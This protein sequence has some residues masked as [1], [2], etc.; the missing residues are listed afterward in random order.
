MWLST[1]SRGGL[2]TIDEQW[3]LSRPLMLLPCSLASLLCDNRGDGGMEYK[4]TLSRKR[5]RAL[6]QEVPRRTCVCDSGL[7]YAAVV[8]R[9]FAT[10]ANLARV[11]SADCFLGLALGGPE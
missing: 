10:S 11:G 3:N 6:A 9:A 2:P 8:A 1:V 7:A 4:S 5:I